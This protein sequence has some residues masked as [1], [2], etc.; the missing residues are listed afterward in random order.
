MAQTK[1]KEEILSACQAQGVKFIELQ[2][3]DLLGQLKAVTIPHNKLESAIGNNVWFDGSSIEGFARIFE[4]DM[5]LKLD[6]STFA[7]LPWT[8]NNGTIT[9]RFICDVYHPNGRPYESDPRYILKKQ[10]QRAAQM[11]LVYYVGPE[12]EFFLLKRVRDKVY[13]VI[14]DHAGYFDQ[15]FG[16]SVEL[17]K[18]MSLALQALQIDVETLHHEVA[19]SQHEIDFRY[20]DPIK[21][22]DNAVSFKYALKTL[23]AQHEMHATFMPKPFFGINGSGMHVHQSLFSNGENTFYDPTDHHKLSK[24]AKKFIAGQLKHI[25]AMNAILNPTINSYKRLVAG[26]EAPV[27]ITWGTTNRSALIRVPKTNPDNPASTRVELRCPDPTAN[28]YLSF[29]VMLAAGL[30][31]LANE[32]M[33]PI[34]T[35]ENVYD[36]SAEE[37]NKRKIETLPAD[38]RAALTALKNDSVIRQVLGEDTYNKYH[39]IKINEWNNFCSAVTDWEKSNYLEQ[40]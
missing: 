9:A 35:E 30:D 17:R 27:Y 11:G 29:A 7:I 33:I 34:A 40:Y 16:S 25:K 12:L 15:S 18:E 39:N 20:D 32:T 28:P 14:A 19:N 6:L 4:S 26:Y 5:Y 8:Q 22:A 37:M 10:V 2:F 23:S 21:T 38:L 3:T 13:P 24:T 31:G 36:L 1:T